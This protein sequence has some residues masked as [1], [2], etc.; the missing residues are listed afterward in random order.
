MGLGATC[1]KGPWCSVPTI[2]QKLTFAK[3]RDTVLAATGG[4][5]GFR[6]AVGLVLACEPPWVQGSRYLAS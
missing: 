3:R 5:K 6:R 4:A 2:P 1:R